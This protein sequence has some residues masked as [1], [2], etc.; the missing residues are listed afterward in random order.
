MTV[1]TGVRQWPGEGLTRVPYWS[2][3]D[4]DLYAQEQERIFRG[5]T[6]NFLCLEAELPRPNTFRTSDLGD[7]PV[8]VTRDGDGKL[9][10]FENR[11]AHRGSLLCLNDAGEARS[12]VCVYH[13]WTYDLAGNLRGVAFRRGLGGQGGMPDDCRPERHGPRQLRVATL[14]GLIFGTLS[15][16]TPPLETYL[17]PQIVENIRRV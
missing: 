4:Q 9:H 16:A 8:V 7:M 17:G 5:N 13:N 10:A 3:S 14:N 12:I 2:Y 6:W 11:C 1:H 15:E